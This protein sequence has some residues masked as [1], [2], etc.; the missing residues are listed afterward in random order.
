ME[1]AGSRVGVLAASAKEVRLTNQIILAARPGVDRL[2]P[3]VTGVFLRDPGQKEKT[4]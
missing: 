3:K 2:P 1:H 4:L